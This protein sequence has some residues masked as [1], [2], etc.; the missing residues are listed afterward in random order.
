M[1]DAINQSI[2]YL[3]GV[4]PVDN[5]PSTA[6]APPIGKMQPFRKIAVTH[7]PVMQ[8]RCPPKI[9]SPT[10]LQYSSFSD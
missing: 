8:F 10:K 5:I 9:K 6:K 4:G 1:T 2:N 3:D 7:E